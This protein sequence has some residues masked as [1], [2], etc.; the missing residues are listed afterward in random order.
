[1][2]PRPGAGVDGPAVRAWCRGRLPQHALPRY[3]R[4]LADLPRTPNGKVV[5]R[6]LSDT[7][8]AAGTWDAGER[9]GS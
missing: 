3:V 9:P 1:V 5:K 6:V 8:V 7:G 2:V 4:V